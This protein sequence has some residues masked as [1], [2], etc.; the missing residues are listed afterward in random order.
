[1][2]NIPYARR[3][4]TFSATFHSR[5][6]TVFCAN[7]GSCNV[8][9]NF[10]NELRCYD[11]GNKAIWDGTGFGILRPG[12]SEDLIQAFNNHDQKHG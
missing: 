4:H 8:D 1:M 2:K 9:Q 12:N 10:I 11:C 3:V 5:G 7:C 6:A